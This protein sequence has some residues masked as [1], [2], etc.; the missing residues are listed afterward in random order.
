MNELKEKFSCNGTWWKPEHPD[1]K[2]HGTLSYNYQ[3]GLKLDLKGEF[4]SENFSFTEIINGISEKG[5]QITLFGCA[6]SRGSS[7]TR[8][9]D[10]SKYY[11]YRYSGF[12][13]SVAY[14]SHHFLTSDEIKFQK[15]CF[16]L[17][18]LNEWLGISGFNVKQELDHENDDV[19]FVIEYSRPKSIIAKINDQ[20]S[21]SIDFDFSQPSYYPSSEVKMV[22][23]PRITIDSNSEEKL[24]NF[25]KILT[26]IRYFLSLGIMTP[27]YPYN[28]SGEIVSENL[29]EY[30]R[31]MK[32]YMRLDASL[33]VEKKIHFISMLFTYKD[34]QDKFG[35]LI[36]IWFEK[37]TLLEPV[38]DLYFSIYFNPEMPINNQ[39]L[40]AVQAIESYHRRFKKNELLAKSEFKKMKQGILDVLP[41][42]QQIWLKPKL[43][44]AN[45]P[46]LYYRLK[47]LF[48]EYCELGFIFGF[49]RDHFAREVTDTRNYLTHYSSNLEKKALF[50]TDIIKATQQLKAVIQYLILLELGFTRDEAQKFANKITTRQFSQNFIT[51]NL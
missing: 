27:V 40:G 9:L 37:R 2:I 22:Q 50:G 32:I 30:D 12:F 44:F 10:T 17:N 3:E 4:N 42:D 23:T 31:W 16:S 41:E 8:R 21:M 20:F 15:I 26:Q 36:R 11:S 33:D 48:S 1:D 49:N 29:K 39:F 34:I 38:I 18:N 7:G 35:D 45:E 6:F 47:D 46:S 51:F 14:T 5:I 24:S 13:C 43:D 25:L 28:F 19:K